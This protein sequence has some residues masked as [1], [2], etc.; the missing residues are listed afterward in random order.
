MYVQQ[1]A[2]KVFNFN[3]AKTHLQVIAPLLSVIRCNL[4]E[5]LQSIIKVFGEVYAK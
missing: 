3:V 4:G 2:V 5:M 1:S